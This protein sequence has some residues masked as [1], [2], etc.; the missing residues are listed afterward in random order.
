MIH[1]ENEYHFLRRQ[2]LAIS[3][4]SEHARANRIASQMDYNQ[5]SSTID[6]LVKAK[7]LK[8]QQ[9]WK[10]IILHYTYERRFAHYKSKIHQIWNQSLHSTS[11]IETKLIIGTRTNPNLTKELVRRSPRLQKRKQEKQEQ[12]Q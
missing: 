4:K 6:P 9:T 10:S 8:R 7:L 5:I 2:I 11:A 1:D 3:T 12:L